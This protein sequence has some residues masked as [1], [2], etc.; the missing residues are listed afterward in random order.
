[1]ATTYRVDTNDKRLTAIEDKQAADIKDSDASFDKM[2]ADT[3]TEYNNAMSKWDTWEDTQTDL[4]NRRHEQTVKEIEQKKADLKSD[5]TKEQSGAYVDWQ[6]Q[7][8]EYGVNAEKAA[9]SGMSNSGFTANFENSLYNT[10]QNRV[11]AARE[12]YMRSLTNYENNINQ[13]KLNNDTILA[14]IAAEAAQNQMQLSLQL[15]TAK[16][17]LLTQKAEA[18]LRIKSN[19]QS[20]YQNMMDTIMSEHRLNEDARQADMANK[21][22]QEQI[23]IAQAELKIKQEQWEQEKADKEAAA[24]AARLAKARSA[25]AAERTRQQKLTT[26]EKKTNKTKTTSTGTAVSKKTTSSDKV[27]PKYEVD[28][29]SVLALGFGPISPSAL[30]R[31]VKNGIVEEYVSGGKLKYRKTAATLKQGML[32]SKLG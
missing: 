10:Y 21:R 19:W 5:Y 12:S 11:A 26:Q 18:N 17:N 29:K 30:D 23:A 16:N 27:S 8:D 25:A 22:A 7:S 32:Y 28:T 6:K 24:E 31:Y 9:A 4:Q 13:A 14:E 3:K 15:L 1:M 2:L 20:V